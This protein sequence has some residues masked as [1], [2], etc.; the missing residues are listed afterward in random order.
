[1]FYPSLTD[2]Q[3]SLTIHNASSSEF[4]LKVMSFVSILVPFV[5]AYIAYVWYSMDKKKLTPESLEK[6]DHK[7]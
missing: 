1:P 7:Y 2:P 3:S 4:T 5:V 6:T